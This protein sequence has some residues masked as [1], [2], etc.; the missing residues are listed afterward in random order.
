MDL[1]SKL[2][3][4]IV[5]VLLFA[6]LFSLIFLN[7]TFLRPNSDEIRFVSFLTGSFPNFIAA[8]LI[9]LCIVNPVLIKNPK[10]GKYIVYIGSFLIFAILAIEELTPMWG[11]STQFDTF[12]IIASG[13]GSSLAILTFEIIVLMRKNRIKETL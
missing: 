4:I 7:K 10:N 13:L 11:A 3:I 5:N 8:Y 6:L 1:K 12:D 2:R 9:S